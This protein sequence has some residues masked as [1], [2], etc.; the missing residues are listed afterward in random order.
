MDVDRIIRIY[1]GMQE[2]G[3]SVGGGFFAVL[4][5]VRF[6]LKQT[7]T[8]ALLAAL[9]AFFF[10]SYWIHGYFYDPNAY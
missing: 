7:W 4:L 6:T 1:E 8:T 2:S 5:L 10:T 3:V 9:S